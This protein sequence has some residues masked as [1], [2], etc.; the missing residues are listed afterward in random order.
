MPGGPSLAKE[1]GVDGKTVWTALGQLEKEGLLIAQGPGKR[2]RIVTKKKLVTPILRIA[3]LSYEPLE[4][5]EDWIIAIQKKLEH[6]GHNAFFTKKSLLELG[7]DVLRLSQLVKQT[8][9]GAWI[10]CSGSRG[11]LEWFVDQEI[12]AFALFGR[13]KQLPIAGVGPNQLSSACAATRRLIQLGHRRIVVLMRESQREGVTGS[14]ELAIFN[15]MAAH[16]IPTSPY[17]RPNWEDTPEGFHSRLEELFRITPPTALIIDEPFLFHAAKDHLAQRGILAPKHVSLICTDPDR[18][19]A[20]SVPTIAHTHWETG[21]VV[22]R[23]VQWVNHIASGKV[24]IKQTLTKAEFIDGG[25]VG[26]AVE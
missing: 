16:G 5:V 15:E 24:D 2:R 23:V 17:N 20:W 14:R 26:M 21:P 8:P 11:V 3:I 25:T 12:P 4:L 22:R 10:V 7:P 1:L 13:R 9:A 18:T 19:F 6:Q